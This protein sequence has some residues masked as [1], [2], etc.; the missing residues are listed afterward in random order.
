MIYDTNQ[1]WNSF[2]ATLNNSDI[3]D[4]SPVDTG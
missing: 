2:L 1:I 3:W 4:I